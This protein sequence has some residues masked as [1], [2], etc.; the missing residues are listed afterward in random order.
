[1]HMKKILVIAGAA[2]LCATLVGVLIALFGRN[3]SDGG[4]DLTPVYRAEDAFP[5]MRSSTWN[6]RTT[7]ICRM[8]VA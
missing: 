7:F 1:M 2:L 8:A 5:R 3:S 6:A 4:D